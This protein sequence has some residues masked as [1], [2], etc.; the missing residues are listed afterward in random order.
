[1]SRTVHPSRRQP[2]RGSLLRA[3]VGG[4]AAVLLL[5]ACGGEDPEPSSAATSAAE[6]GSAGEDATEFCAQ[7][8][9]IDARVDAALSDLEGDVSLADGFTRL[10]EELRGIQAPEAIVAD[11]TALADGLDR[12]AAAVGTVDLTDLDSLEALD[13][14]AS[15]LDGPSDNVDRYLEDECGI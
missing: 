9:D 15:G 1:M 4:A 6:Q 13:Q 7:A 12:V 14:A 5:T 8:G 10:A 3:G 11:W 2:L